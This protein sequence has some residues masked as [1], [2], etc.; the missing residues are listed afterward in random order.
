M[1]SNIISIMGNAITTRI[2]MI[3]SNPSIV[4]YLQN[5]PRSHSDNTKEIAENTARRA[6]GWFSNELEM[7]DIMTRVSPKRK[8]QVHS[9]YC[10]TLSVTASVVLSPATALSAPASFVVEAPAMN[11]RPR[12][13]ANIPSA[14]T[15]GDITSFI[16][17]RFNFNSGPSA[18]LSV[19]Y[20]LVVRKV[21][22][23]MARKVKIV[24]LDMTTETN[25]IIPV[26][27]TTCST[28][29]KVALAK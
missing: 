19:V 15:I 6:V 17:A 25:P 16:V 10:M 5:L 29:A 4:A 9:T 20:I 27:T 12:Y 28:A 13:M 1:L 11:R 26:R 7:K 3:P 8:V 23:P 18:F 22:T 14:M 21:S 2:A 24:Y